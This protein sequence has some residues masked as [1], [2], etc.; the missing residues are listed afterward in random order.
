DR[1]RLLEM[2]DDF[3]DLG[4]QRKFYRKATIDW[5]TPRTW[6]PKDRE[7]DV[8]EGWAGFGGIYAMIRR[9]GRQ[10]DGQRIAY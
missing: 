5:S 8:P 4:D 1:M 9:H 6:N 3:E 10:L 7:F 2:W